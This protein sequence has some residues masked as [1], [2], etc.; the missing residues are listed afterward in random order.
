MGQMFWLALYNTDVAVAL[1]ITR[2][3]RTNN[4]NSD[5]QKGIINYVFFSSHDDVMNFRDLFFVLQE[6]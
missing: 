5:K 2:L 3:T 6:L 4:T 1:I